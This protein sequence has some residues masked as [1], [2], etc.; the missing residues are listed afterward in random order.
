MDAWV[1]HAYARLQEHQLDE[2]ATM[3][4]LALGRFPNH[5]RS[6]LGL[7]DVR[8]RQGRRAETEAALSRGLDAI[9]LLREHR[10][11]NEAALAAATAE[12]LAG[13]ADRATKVLAD[14][15]D[16]APPGPA[17]W[18][19]AIEPAFASLRD[20]PAFKSVLAQV[21]ERAV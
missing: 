12:V 9:D 8:F 17:G 6:W 19:L 13:R 14:F 15:I 5:A 18:T 10:R 20:T 1:G 3:F 2:A 4:E 11:L 21:A 16:D 7:A